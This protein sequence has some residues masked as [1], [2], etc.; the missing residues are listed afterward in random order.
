MNGR[1]D[2]E[3]KSK[4]EL[5]LDLIVTLESRYAVAE[6]CVQD[7]HVWPIIRLALAYHLIVRTDLRSDNQVSE[8]RSDTARGKRALKT[9]VKSVFAYL[10]DFRSNAVNQDEH[11]DV[12]FVVC[13]STRFFKIGTRW[14]NPYCDSFVTALQERNISSVV[15]ETAADAIYRTP[16]YRPSVY[17][18]LALFGRL[19]K[20]LMR[21]NQG[22]LEATIANLP[23]YA[24][25][26]ADVEAAYP[27]TGMVSLTEIAR[28]ISYCEELTQYFERRLHRVQPSVV[29][30]EGYYA[31]DRMALYCACRRMGIRSIEVQHGVQGMFH[32]AYSRWTRVPVDG[33]EMLPELFWVWSDD[34]RKNIQEWAGGSPRAHSAFVG[35][36]PTL[37]VLPD[38][39][40]AEAMRAILDRLRQGAGVNL[41]VTLQASFDI[42]EFLLEAVRDSPGSW[43]WWFRLHPQYE[44][45]GPLIRAQIV[46]LGLSD[47][48]I[49]DQTGELPMKFLLM[50]VNVH[51]T[52]FSSSVLEAEALGVPSILISERGRLYYSDQIARGTAIFAHDSAGVLQTIR[53]FMADDHQRE[54]RLKIIAEE[55]RSGID[56]VAAF[57]RESASSAH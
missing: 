48:V 10:R 46:R 22:V 31:I 38:A 21:S 13:S 26:T 35:G 7:V 41:L 3:M 2:D 52:E 4:Q 8:Y 51:L 9:I 40:D 53:R 12:L 16:R 47:R 23:G 14:Y 29:I 6:W 25:L 32:V 19:V 55:F 43:R 1:D 36:N 15:L 18:Q 33:Y 39:R 5:I 30:S 44:D 11:R 50:I 34:E 54:G 42:P 57:V 24:A 28:R 17:I 27:E 37:N 20:A 49:I 45:T 56:C